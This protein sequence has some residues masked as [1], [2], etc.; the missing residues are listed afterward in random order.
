[1]ETTMNKSL[2][3]SILFATIGGTILTLPN[4]SIAFPSCDDINATN[5]AKAAAFGLCGYVAY[6][7]T[8]FCYNQFNDHIENKII[9]EAANNIVLALTSNHTI[10]KLPTQQ[11]EEAFRAKSRLIG[12]RKR[13]ITNLKN[14]LADSANNLSSEHHKALQDKISLADTLFAGI[15][16]VRGE[17][18]YEDE[19]ETATTMDA[20]IESKIINSIILTCKPNEECSLDELSQKQ[21]LEAR[22]DKIVQKARSHITSYWGKKL[23]SLAIIAL[24]MAHN[25]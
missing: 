4:S 20:F 16:L 17:N 19:Y 24:I 13:I 10:Q 9:I 3:R 18:P 25:I 15:D 2:V 23:L 21:K 5:V 7:L 22:R 11:R 8:Y 12:M 6:K 14:M 1:M